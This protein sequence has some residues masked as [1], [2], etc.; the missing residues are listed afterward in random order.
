M[1]PHRASL[2][3]GLR[4]KGALVLLSAVS[5]IAFPACGS[6]VEEAETNTVREASTTVTFHVST[7]SKNAT[8]ANL[9]GS[10]SLWPLT[11]LVVHT[12]TPTNHIINETLN[13]AAISVSQSEFDAIPTSGSFD[14]GLTGTDSPPNFTVAS[15]TVVNIH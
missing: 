7:V 11:K 1:S 2:W 6:V 9:T 4:S 10:I 13:N 15:T 5:V 12:G 14:L 8:V 3:T